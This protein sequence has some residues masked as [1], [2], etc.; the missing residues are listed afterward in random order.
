LELFYSRQKTEIELQ[1]VLPD[2]TNNVTLY[3]PEKR[4]MWRQVTVD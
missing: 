2:G 4:D 3:R 1:A